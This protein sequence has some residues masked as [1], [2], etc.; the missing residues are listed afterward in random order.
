MYWI[1]FFQ[2]LIISNAEAENFL[3]IGDSLSCGSFG[4]H[5]AKE[6]RKIESSKT[7]EGAET[8][9]NKSVLFCTES[10]SAGNWVK[11]TNPPGFNCKNLDEDGEVLKSCG[12]NGKTPTLKS[13]LDTYDGYTL[14]IGLGTNSLG[15]NKVDENYATLA[16]TIQAK[17]TKCHWVG[18]PDLDPN[19][20][21]PP[22]QKNILTLSLNLS[23]FYNSLG[24]TVGESCTLHN[25]RE[26][27]KRGT[28]GFETTDGVHRTTA[29]GRYWAEQLINN[30]DN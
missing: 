29:A 25:S 2:I 30:L 11:G 10:S 6:L 26:W 4:T 3:I 5:L 23:G 14:I 28:P 16:S 19:S 27:T 21:K 8:V 17:K 13:L 20:A 9:K 1:L 18:P 15:A 12:G 22:Q 7:G 24:D